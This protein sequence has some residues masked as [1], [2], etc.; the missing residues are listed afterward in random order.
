M[1]PNNFP[2]ISEM[3]KQHIQGLFNDD[4]SLGKQF[5][6]LEQ[7]L[8]DDGVYLPADLASFLHE[9]YHFVILLL[10]ESKKQVDSLHMLRKN[11]VPPVV[12]TLRANVRRAHGVFGDLHHLVWNSK[13]F[14]WYITQWQ[15]KPIS[16]R[17]AELM[18]RPPSAPDVLRDIPEDEPMDDS[19][20][21]ITENSDDDESEPEEIG[22]FATEFETVE[23]KVKFLNSL[24]GPAHKTYS[25]LCLVT[26][27]VH[28]AMRFKRTTPGPKM[29][30]DFQVIKYPMADLMMKS[31]EEMISEVA[32][33]P[34]LERKMLDALRDKA[35][36]K[37]S[38][39]SA[40]L[41]PG[42]E[43]KFKGRAHCEAVLGCL[44]SVAKR[45]QSMS[46][47]SFFPNKFLFP[48]PIYHD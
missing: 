47:V 25:W 8:D 28:H 19:G 18:K 29:K 11:H 36:E 37:G 34:V 39:F 12:E 45:D 41:L 40:F 42:P 9:F 43:R 20:F 46:W 14:K 23:D 22:E 26:S 13:F 6:L 30:L 24:Y 1:L 5:P 15:G 10:R 17:Y 32:G 48:L 2:G 4:L 27:A 21:L 33:D 35:G 7:F 38:R 44:H 3:D 16:R 31:W